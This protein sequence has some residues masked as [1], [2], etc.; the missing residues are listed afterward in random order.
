MLES[1]N[2]FFIQKSKLS[3]HRSLITF[4]K[5]HHNFRASKF[6]VVEEEYNHLVQLGKGDM[7]CLHPQP[8]F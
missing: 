3:C 7:V 8:E 1:G 6:Q 5:F 2:A 4:L